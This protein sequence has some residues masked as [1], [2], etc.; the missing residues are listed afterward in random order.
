[1]PKQLGNF[2]FP[3]LSTTARDLITWTS[4]AIIY[5]TTTNKLE[6]YNGSIWEEATGGGGGGGLTFADVWAVNTLINC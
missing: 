2:T 6:C 1:M 4:G 5:N 3:K